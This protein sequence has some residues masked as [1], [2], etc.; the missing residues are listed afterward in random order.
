[1]VDRTQTDETDI[2]ITILSLPLLQKLDWRKTE[3]F[4]DRSCKNEES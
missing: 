1:M 3:N 4:K 2:P